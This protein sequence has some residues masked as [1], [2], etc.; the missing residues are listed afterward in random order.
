MSGLTLTGSAAGNYTLSQPTG[1]SNNIT[2][3]GV[4]ISSGITANGKPYDGTTTATI[5]S[6]NV[7]LAGVLAGDVSNVKLSTNGYVANF[8]TPNVGT[9][10]GV[11][12]SGLTLTG[13]A[14]GNY[15][16]SQP[17]GL[18]NNITALGVT[19]S[20][21]IT[22]NG[23]PYD[24][25]T[26]AT[27]SSNNVVLA[28]V[29]AGDVSN[30]QL[31]TNGYVA[32]FV[33]PNVGTGIGV[34]VSGL[35]L[36]GSA[37]GNYT[38]S[39]PTGLSNNITALGVTISSG[40]TANGKPYDGT[41]TATI[42]SNNVVLA[43]VLAGDVSNVKLSTNGYVANFV[44]PNV[45]TGIGVTV[46]GLTL[47][48]SAA[49]NYTLSQPT[50]LS[51]NITALG[52]TISSGITANGKPYDGTTTATISSNN[53]VLA[54]VLA[55]DVSNVKLSTNGYVANF[56]SPNVGTGIGVTVSGLT[57]TGSAAGNYTLSQPT[58]LSNNIT[59]LGVTISSGITANGKPYDGT[60]TATISSNNVVLAGV[61]AGD[62][63]NVKLSTNGYV[64][65]FVSPNVGTGIGVT[66][67]GLTLTGS[68]AGNYTLSQPTG[69]SN[70][71]TALGVTI[72][73]GI[74]ANGK[75]YDGTTTATISSNNVVLAGV[76]AGDVSN[77]KLS[78]NGYVA[79]FVSPNVGTGIGVT[80][81]GLTLTGSA[82]GNYTLSQPTGL[83][84]N[85]TALGVTISSGITANGKP[86]DGTTTATISSNNVVLAGVLAG[87]VSNVKLSTN[88]YVAN[89]VSPNVGTGIGVTVS[90][91]TLTGSAAGNYTLS[92]P[93]G[94]SNNITAL[95]VTISSG[96][97]ANGKP[98]DGTTTATISSNNVVLAGVLAGDVSNVKLST[99]GYVANFV[100]PNVGTGIGV[101]VSG[102][103]LTGSAAGNYT[104]SQP[105]GLSNNIT[106]LGVTISSGITA[107]GKPYDGTTTATIS[108]NNVVLAGV[109]AGDVSNV[110]LSTNGYVAN[111]VS[112]NVGTGIGVTVSG[113][114]L[115]G[116]AAGN[117][118]L[119]QPTGLSNN[120]T[121]L[122]VT[123]SSGITANGKPYDGTTTATISSNNVVLAGVLAGDVSNVKLSTNGYV[124]NFVSPNVGTGIGV[125]VSGLTLTGSAAGNYT[126]SQPTGLSNNITALGVTISSGITANGKPYDGTT[127][128]TISSN[129]VVLAGVL[130]GDVSN[131]QAFNERVCGKLCEPERGYGDWSDGERIDA[132]R[133]CGRELHA[134]PADGI[135]Q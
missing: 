132:D 100:S 113:L 19:I 28:G 16:L 104:L 128:A 125:T 110:Q 117:Y 79:N 34:T 91:L 130:A 74:T 17:T 83:S 133:K 40:I 93:T 21:G 51:N 63:S 106:A 76:L 61:L 53:V 135:E 66:V 81:S 50:G 80:V 46:S 70:N 8:V 127:T 84:N 27:I 18:S 2:A 95:G 37:A 44:S 35:T 97:T 92:Q 103:T 77:V 33:S 56:V 87:D 52:V 15:T 120:I 45:G 30:V 94:L 89:F 4:T 9:G 60:T 121:A 26:T 112:P 25:T 12:V 31:S 43:G 124:A 115:T 129:N 90:G 131:V 7:V 73:S 59:A 39:Q 32:N 107:N 23:K 111:F 62:V 126:L 58:G 78:T 67:S 98:Y 75:P 105:T 114:T 102:L 29:L 24:G 82:A 122:G 134:E 96:I 6:N 123:I 14:A 36:T 69:L 68:A 85:I 20:S 47:T 11:M 72:S 57:L 1:L 55:G 10:I 3:L 54:G 13:S 109:L 49:G 116:S 48:G 65:N 71:I 119:S 64:A 41:T 99:N 5:S 38:L 42:S 108:S 118:T 101:T 88:G 22:A 86:Y